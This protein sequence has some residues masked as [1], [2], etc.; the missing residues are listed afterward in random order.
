MK[1]SAQVLVW[2]LLATLACSPLAASTVTTFSGGDPGEGL[3]LQGT[4]VAAA[5]AQPDGTSI[6]VGDAIFQARNVSLNTVWGG[7]T[8]TG[9]G[10]P[11]YGG[12]TN[13]INLAA[14]ND[15]VKYDGVDLVPPGN[16]GT[17]PIDITGLVA[18][19]QYKLQLLYNEACCNRGF[20]VYVNGILQQLDLNPSSLQL[21]SQ[22]VGVV[23]TGT[24]AATG[25][26]QINIVEIGHVGDPDRNPILDALT[27]ETVPEPST[28]VLLSLGAIGLCTAARRRRTA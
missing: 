25:S 2:A 14:V 4:F 23:F 28:V 21:G 16:F 1:S 17:M 9:F 3:D 10:G 19:A 8:E 20:D 5:H 6:Q 7:S 26:G 24:Y 15:Y 27:L 12:S 13:D 11:N 18:G 22:S